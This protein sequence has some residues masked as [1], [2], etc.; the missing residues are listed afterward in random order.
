MVLRD[1]NGVYELQMGE[2]GD[3]KAYIVENRT[4]KDIPIHYQPRITMRG[5]MWVYDDEGCVLRAEADYIQIYRAGNRG[6]LINLIGDSPHVEEE[7]R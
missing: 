1:P 7:L 2:D 3:Y 5:W 6:I 4:V